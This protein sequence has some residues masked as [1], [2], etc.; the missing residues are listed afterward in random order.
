MAEL[1]QHGRV[2]RCEL[3]GRKSQQSRR[4]P[5]DSSITAK[6][7]GPT[8]FSVTINVGR[9]TE[10]GVVPRAA[11]P[12]PRCG[13]GPYGAIPPSLMVQL[14]GVPVST[15]RAPTAGALYLLDPAPKVTPGLT[16][17]LAH[18]VSNAL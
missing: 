5:C 13:R 7:H 17:L 16:G 6:L 11:G 4:N 12:N 9:S 2:K 1:C 14:F 10:P 3:V 18:P 15:P 8:L